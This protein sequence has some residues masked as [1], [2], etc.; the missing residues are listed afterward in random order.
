MYAHTAPIYANFD[1]VL[2]PSCSSLTHGR[3][4][5]ARARKRACTWTGIYTCSEC[6]CVRV[7]TT[8]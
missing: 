5:R 7:C 1:R 4:A 3:G 6:A 8:T 2:D